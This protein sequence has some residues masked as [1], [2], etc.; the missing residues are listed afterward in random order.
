M[1]SA[2]A[3][4]DCSSATAWYSV[5]DL[6]EFGETLVV[7]DDGEEVSHLRKHADAAGDCVENLQLLFVGDG[8]IHQDF[9]QLAA[10]GK[11]FAEVVKLLLGCCGIQMRRGGDGGEGMGV[12][13]GE[14]GH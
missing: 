6:V 1:I 2:S 14:D 11:G 7:H 3:R 13:E 10:A 12:A 9:A 8:G 4:L 5:E